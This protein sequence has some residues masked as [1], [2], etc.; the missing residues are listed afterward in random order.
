MK[1]TQTPFSQKTKPD[2]DLSNLRYLTDHIVKTIDL[3]D[4]VESETGERLGLR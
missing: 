3:P 4:F 2:L 1:K